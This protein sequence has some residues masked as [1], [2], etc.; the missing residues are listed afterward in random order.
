MPQ[1]NDALLCYALAG[2]RITSPSLRVAEVCNAIA[3]RNC[4]TQC[5][6]LASLSLANLCHC[7]VKHR[8]AVAV[9]IAALP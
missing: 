8:H 3:L 2:R 5:L 9:P 7:Y 4:S 6:C 1:H